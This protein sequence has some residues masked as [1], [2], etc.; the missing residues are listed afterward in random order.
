MMRGYAETWDC[1][2]RFLL[3][4]FGEEAPSEHCERCDNN[5]RLDRPSATASAEEPA[6]PFAVGAH[7]RHPVWGEGRIVAA[8]PAELTVAFEQGEEKTLAVETVQEKQLLEVI[9]EPSSP[10]ADPSDAPPFQVGERVEHPEY[11][12]GEVVRVSDDSGVVLF[13]QSGYHTL[14][15]HR[16]QDENLLVV[17]E[18]GA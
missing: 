3:N 11:G 15:L 18:E 9:S 16:V 10:A 4:Y 1:R 2:R 8:D 5:T 12:P 6:S 7:V 17:C 14:D 13:D